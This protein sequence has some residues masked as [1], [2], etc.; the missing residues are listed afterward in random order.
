MRSQD[1]G[2]QR[3]KIFLKGRR[4]ELRA[5]KQVLVIKSR[6][7][8]ATRIAIICKFGGSMAALVLKQLKKIWKQ[9]PLKRQSSSGWEGPDSAARRMHL[10]SK[11]LVVLKAQRAK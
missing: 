3:T 11:P 7:G 4:P 6:K 5:R 9:C 1:T 2:D 8:F 10:R